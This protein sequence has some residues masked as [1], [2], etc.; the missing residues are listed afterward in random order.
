[1]TT[2]NPTDIDALRLRLSTLALLC[3]ALPQLLDE[4]RDLRDALTITQSACD[5][6]GKALDE[7]RAEVERLR[8]TS[9]DYCGECGWSMKFPDGCAN[10]GRNDLEAFIRSRCEIVGR[11][12]ED[13]PKAT[14]ALLFADYD[15]LRAKPEASGAAALR[16]ALEKIVAWGPFPATGRRWENGIEMSYGAAFGSNGERDYMRQI[17]RA[18]LAASSP[19]PRGGA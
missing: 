2:P 10:C 9:A 6:R 8:Q 15:A 12:P 16:E 18:A 4:L 17:A 14:L 13:D 5:R 1:M 11:I 7:T 19:E 3:D